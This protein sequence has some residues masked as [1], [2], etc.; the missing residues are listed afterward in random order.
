MENKITSHITKGT[1]IVLITSVIDL[2]GGFAHVKFET[3]FKWIPT[4]VLFAGIIWAC[5]NFGNQSNHNVTFGNVFA[6]GFKTSAV[7]ACLGLIYTLLS[8]YLIFPETKEL[9]LQ[10]AREQ[11]ESG[12]KLTQEQIDAGIEVTKKL[13]LP[14]A[15]AGVILGTLFVGLIASLIGAAATKK[16]PVTPFDNKP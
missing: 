15:I 13:F 2:I 9:A 16:N 4:I 6:H 12:G 11:M 7:V 8:M 10:Q 5:I 3:W 1:I 14:I